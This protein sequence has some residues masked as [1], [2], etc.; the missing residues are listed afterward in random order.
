MT[1]IGVVGRGR[2]SYP[3]RLLLNLARTQDATRE[4]IAIRCY[5]GAG[6]ARRMG[7]PDPT[8]DAIQSLDEHW[9]GSGHPDGLR[10]TPSR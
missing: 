1:A 8:A 7:F 10:A 5:R 9:N 6:I 2:P 3:P 4:L